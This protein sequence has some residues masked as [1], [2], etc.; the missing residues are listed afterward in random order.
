M[1]MLRNSGPHGNTRGLLWQIGLGNWGSPGSLK[2]PGLAQRSLEGSTTLSTARLG[3]FQPTAGCN[4][5][6]GLL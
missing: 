5:V 4:T 1:S 2:A 3:P 6:T